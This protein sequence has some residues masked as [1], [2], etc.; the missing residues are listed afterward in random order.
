ML[1]NNMSDV[2]KSKGIEVNIDALAFDKAD[3]R[4]ENTDILLFGPQIRHL[5]PK[6]KKQ[7]DGKIPVI[8]TINISDYGLIRGEKILNDCMALYEASKK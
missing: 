1:V 2:A 8:E 4:L 5:L 6:F 3:A 7:Y